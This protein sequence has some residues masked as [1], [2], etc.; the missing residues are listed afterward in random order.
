MDSAFSSV[1]G[2]SYWRTADPIRPAIR[3]PWELSVKIKGRP[4]P[5]LKYKIFPG[6][7]S[8]PVRILSEDNEKEDSL[9]GAV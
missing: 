4:L 8:L 7:G 1:G 3:S 2:F 9:L 6:S 5:D